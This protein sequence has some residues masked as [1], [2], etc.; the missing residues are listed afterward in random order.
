[1]G[2]GAVITFH[3]SPTKGNTGVVTKHGEHA[4]WP[5]PNMHIPH[6][7]S[8]ATRAVKNKRKNQGP[9][10]NLKREYLILLICVGLYGHKGVS[11][12]MV[13]S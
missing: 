9:G 5:M 2:H 8:M 12:A 11:V 10:P 7:G 1:M 4:A 13:V 3:G 6:A